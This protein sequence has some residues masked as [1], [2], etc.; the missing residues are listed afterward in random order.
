MPD[1]RGKYYIECYCRSH[2]NLS[3]RK[4]DF[5]L[6]TSVTAIIKCVASNRET[7]QLW[8]VQHDSSQ[9]FSQVSQRS[10]RANGISAL[11]FGFSRLSLFV[12][13]IALLAAM[14]RCTTIASSTTKQRS[15]AAINRLSFLHYLPTI[16][17]HTYSD[18]FL[19]RNVACPHDLSQQMLRSNALDLTHVHSSTF[20][21]F[22]SIFSNPI[23]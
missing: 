23:C 9:I 21:L 10:R 4:L 19:L 15:T 5:C 8:G 14:L 16:T 6:H 22:L 7:H 3:Y 20:Q 1:F 13:D 2:H 11:W 17:V 12:E 18:G